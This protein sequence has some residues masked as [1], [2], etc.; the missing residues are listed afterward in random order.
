MKE[1]ERSSFF[2]PRLREP[3]DDD[4]E[5]INWKEQPFLDIAQVVK[6]RLKAITQHVKENSMNV[7]QQVANSGGGE[8]PA[9]ISPKDVGKS[10]TVKI[11]GVSGVITTAKF[12]GIALTIKK[13]PDKR[14]LLLAFDRYDLGAVAA[15]LGS[16]ETDDWIGESIKLVTKSGKK[17]GK[18]VNVWNP[19][20]ER[21][22]KGKKAKRTK[23][24]K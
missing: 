20:M 8:R 19:P 13:G 21:N 1:A 16:S 24:S 23:K 2:R 6:D 22:S 7:A 14:G 10:A 4:E 3:G 17:G 15:Q 5:I 11:I 18:F 12:N 9:L